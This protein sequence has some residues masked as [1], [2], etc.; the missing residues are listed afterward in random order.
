[1]AL[2]ENCMQDIIE[3]NGL[4]LILEFL[5]ENPDDHS[6]QEAELSACERVQQKSAIALNRF[7]KKINYAQLLIE[8]EG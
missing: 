7:A 5:N 1:M 3:F 4:N 8:S 6:N 2:Y